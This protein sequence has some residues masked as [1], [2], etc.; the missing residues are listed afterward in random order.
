MTDNNYI[1]SQQLRAIQHCCIAL[2]LGLMAGIGLTFAALGAITIWPFPAIDYQ[3]PGDLSIWRGAHSGIL[4]NGIMCIVLTACLGVVEADERSARRI[5][6]GLLFMVWANTI[7]YVARIWGTNR[8]LALSSEKFGEGN[9]FD[10]IAMFPALI[11]VGISS[12]AV[13]YLF[14]LARRAARKSAAP[15]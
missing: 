14:V 1:R 6:S 12:Y 7:F 10:G 2:F 11:G 8:G 9:F 4:M 15:L 13:L 5:T 3:I